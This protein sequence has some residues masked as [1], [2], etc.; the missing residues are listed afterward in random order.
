MPNRLRCAA[1]AAPAALTAGALLLLAAG[2]WGA[3]PAAGSG[4]TGAASA[5]A[6]ASAPAGRVYPPADLVRRDGPQQAAIIR[7]EIRATLQPETHRLEAVDVLTVV[8][9]PQTPADEP[10]SFLL[11]KGLEVVSV[12]PDPGGPTGARRPRPRAAG[13]PAPTLPRR[14]AFD[15]RD[16][17]DLRAFWERPPYDELEGFEHA[18]QIDVR[19]NPAIGV[20]P[21]TLRMVVTYRGELY[22]SLRAPKAAYS[23]SFEE[24]AGLIEPRGAFLSGASFWVPSRP[25]EVF[26]FRLAAAAPEGWRVV[27]QGA[28][29]DPAPEEAA[30]GEAAPAGAR[31]GGPAQAPGRVAVW[32][33]PHPMEEV[34]LVAGPW[35]LHER[36]HGGVRVQAFTYAGTDSSIYNRYLRGTGRYLDLYG[37]LIGPYPF[38]KFALVENFW[39]TGFGMP[40]F[41]LLGDR[42]IRLPFILDTSYGHEIL[43]NWWGN[44][45]FVDY[46]QG[47]WCEGLT[48]Y[49]ADY[50]YREREGPDAARDYRRGA[51]LSYTDYV[52]GGEDLPLAA[53]RGRHD[54]ATQAIGYSKSMMVI[55]QLRRESGEDRFHDALRDFFRRNLWRRATWSDLLASFER[56]AG[57]EAG[58]FLAQWVERG[59]APV[60]SVSE[61]RVRPEGDRWRVSAR[62][63]QTLPDGAT[64]E[65]FDLSVPVRVRTEAGDT[66]WNLPLRDRA[67][68]ISVLL[69]SR[70][71]R[72]A[73]DPEFE[74]MRR[75]HRA[76]IPPTLSQTLGA[77][78]VTV[79]LARGLDPSVERA[80]LRLAESWEKGQAL[81]L[82][83]EAD[84]PA[85][86]TP[87]GSAWYFGL[88]PAAARLAA[89]GLAEAVPLGGPSAAA[90]PDGWRIGGVE[91]RRAE[92]SFVLTGSRPGA[93][94]IAWTLIAPRDSAAVAAVGEKIP[95]YGKYSYLVFDGPQVVARG[96]WT[97]SASPLVIDLGTPA[98]DRGRGRGDDRGARH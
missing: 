28:P 96:V 24:T 33:S 50:H 56:A 32:D 98:G 5:G 47:N 66:T 81:R 92:R 4:V 42:V 22:D 3:A 39:Q 54:A 74:M 64:G 80:F 46:A 37:D 57:I 67:A 21:E 30:G 51:L 53:F 6:S 27:S 8:R 16:R 76:E 52:S 36:D 84:R 94:E 95:H 83:R 40:S 48:T 90:T 61:A 65:P 12:T 70:P 91:H 78:S 34:Y 43:H 13:G 1:T 9:A 63:S 93:P 35:D 14:L 82:V 71:R 26:T 86:W 60:L 15:A 73:I 38:A 19:P 41:T 20:W 89:G 97:E 87:S 7:H 62:V 72:L 29:L 77:D 55:H 31:R 45:V 2:S 10:F 69:E 44:G 17:L 68:E 88:G 59:G 23:R 49:G 18:R 25:G 75:V 58:P 11:W 79:V 85:D